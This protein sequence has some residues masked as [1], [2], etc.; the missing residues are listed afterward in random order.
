MRVALD[1]TLSHAF[2]ASRWMAILYRGTG[3]GFM[4]TDQLNHIINHVSYILLRLQFANSTTPLATSYLGSPV[5][6]NI[7]ASEHDHGHERQ[8]ERTLF[9]LPPQRPKG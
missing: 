8:D 9:R 5:L 2:L 7:H 6:Y 4:P 1:Y 3:S